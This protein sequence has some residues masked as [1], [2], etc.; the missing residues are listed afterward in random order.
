MPSGITVEP[1]N[2]GGIRRFNLPIMAVLG[3]ST[4][5]PS[6]IALVLSSVMLCQSIWIFVDFDIDK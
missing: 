4:V 1:L 2:N 6:G 3:G 5:K